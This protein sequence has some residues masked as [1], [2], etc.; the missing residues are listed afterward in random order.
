MVKTT[1]LGL[2]ALGAVGTSSPTVAPQAFEISA[3]AVTMEITSEG[4]TSRANENPG[5]GLTWVTK[6]DKR[7]TIRF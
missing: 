2:A 5:L 6:N 1:I 7:I 4:I 3:G